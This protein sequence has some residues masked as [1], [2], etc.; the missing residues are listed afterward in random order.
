MDLQCRERDP[1][2]DELVQGSISRRRHGRPVFGCQLHREGDYPGNPGVARLPGPHR[3]HWSC[4]RLAR[5]T[6][7]G[8]LLCGRRPHSSRCFG[9]LPDKRCLD[10]IYGQT[11]DADYNCSDPVVV[12][13]SC[14]GTAPDDTPIDTTS[15]TPHNLH[16]FTVTAKRSRR[17]HVHHGGGVLRASGAAGR[18]PAELLSGLG[19]RREPA[20]ARQCDGDRLSDRS[21]VGDRC[22]P[23]VR[24]IRHSKSDGTITF[25]DNPALTYANYVHTGNLDDPFSYEV[26]DLDG[27]VSNVTTVNLTVL[28]QLMTTS[29]P[30]VPEGLT[31]QQPQAQPVDSIGSSCGGPGV[32]LN[33]S[34]LAS[35]GGLAPVTIINDGTANTGWTLSGQISDF[36]DPSAAPETTCD[37][38]ANYNDLCIPGGDLG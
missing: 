23:A 2:R 33:G 27:N 35:C 8:R 15:I 17:Q 32:S 24:R 25:T 19:S 38:P 36:V 3:R 16:T 11:V 30:S 5:N 12:I 18:Q 29:L 26:S 7:P 1:A 14:V 9:S 10:T 21:D 13:T 37:I 31:L 22:Q 28:P 34:E 6:E 4:H 20:G